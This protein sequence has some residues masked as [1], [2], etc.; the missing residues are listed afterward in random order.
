MASRRGA[1]ED[2]AVDRLPEAGPSVEVV[3]LDGVSFGADADPDGARPPHRHDYHEL[4]W[5]RTGTG[6]HLIDG[7]RTPVTPGT[8]TLI[9]RHQVHVFERGHRLSGAAVRFGAELLHGGPTARADPT[10]LLEGRGARVV[11]VPPSEVPRLESTIDSLAAESRRPLDPASIDLER[12]LVSTMLLWLGRWYDASRSRHRPADDAEVEL[13]RRFAAVLERDFARHHEAGHYA[14]ALAVRPAALSRA[15]AQVTGRAT[16]ELIT[17]RVMLEA[18]RLLR[19]TDLTIGEVAFRAGFPDQLYFSRA[20]KRR[21]GQ[22]PTAYR[23]RLRGHD[24]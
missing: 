23:A 19:F 3:L 5:T 17:D 7:E 2:L 15:L 12:H 18:A 20:F 11:A 16:K 1:P 24:G 6:S 10:W 22:A 8:V 14:D 21:S 4:I 13:H 9:G